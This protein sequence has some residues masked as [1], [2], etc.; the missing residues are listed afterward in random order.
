MPYNFCRN[1]FFSTTT[2]THDLPSEISEAVFGLISLSTTRAARRD[3]Q[4][5]KSDTATNATSYFEIYR[6]DYV[7]LTS[8]LRSGGKWHWRFCSSE[9]EV[10]ATSEPFASEQE[11]MASAILLRH[12]AGMAS[13]RTV[14]VM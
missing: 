11:C 6:T 4:T 5:D 1:D 14:S 2:P 9:D 7:L 8:V 13:I 3:W 12:E 10:I